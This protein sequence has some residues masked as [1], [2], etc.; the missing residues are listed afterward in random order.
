MKTHT[1]LAVDDDKTN[2]VAIRSIL[3]EQYNL[4]LANNGQLALRFIE[5][6][7]Y[8]LILLD[9]MMPGMDGMETYRRMRETENGCKVPVI[10]LTADQKAQTE[11]ECLK[12]GAADFCVKPIVPEIMKSRIAH[13]IELEE[14][15]NDLEGKLEKAKESLAK[16]LEEQ[17]RIAA[18]LNIAR[19]IQLD[20]LPSVFPPFPERTE[21]DIHASMTPAKEVGGDFY[22]FFM[23][24]PDHICFVIADVSGKGV[25]AALFMMTSKTRIKDQSRLY[26]SPGK[27]LEM[28]NR[29][30]CENNDSDM[31]VT[32]WLGILEIST[33]ILTMANAGHEYPII[34]R[35]GGTYE[36]IHDHHGPVLAAIDGIRYKEQTLQLCPG[37]V[38][39]LYTDGVAEATRADNEMFGTDR[40][41]E[42]LNEIPRSQVEEITAGMKKALDAFVA[43]APQFDDITMLCV[44]Y[45]A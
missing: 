35:A 37:D 32:V 42:A 44:R 15:R 2:L 19:Q 20:A 24:D 7:H 34:K 9:I 5:K 4:D 27:I 39:Y 23:K 30:L 25:P 28:V 1:I 17:E 8:D 12:M 11:V 41:L 45:N 10:F 21:F 29:Q 33:G 6:K 38:L 36:L 40:M 22:D 18:E 16:V 31:F 43:D 3:G 13:T 14:F 26:D